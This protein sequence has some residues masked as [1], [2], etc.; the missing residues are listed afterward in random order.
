M[1]AARI[2]A[3][4]RSG[5]LRAADVVRSALDRAEAIA[6][7]GAF[8][9][10]DTAGA[11]AR[12]EAIDAAV[13][14]GEDPGPLAGVP[15]A[16]K[17]N[18]AHEGQPCGCAS[19][20]LEGYIAPYTATAVSRLLGA[21]AVVLGRANMDEFAMG[22]STETSAYGPAYNPWDRGRVPG[23]SSGGSAVAVAAGVCPLALGS[24]TGGS[25]RQPASL[26]GVVGVKPTYGRISRYG[27]VAFGSSVDQIGPIG[28][29]VEDA[30]LATALMSGLDGHDPTTLSAPVPDLV[31]ACAAPVRGLTIG[32][33]EEAWGEGVEPGVIA[34]CRAAL[35]ALV[36]EG[37]RVVP[38]RVPLLPLS[39]AIYQVL[40]ASEASSNLARFD[41]VRYGPREAAETLEQLYVRTRSARFGAEV[42]RRILLGTFA[43]SAGYAD[44]YYGRARAAQ[45]RLA[46]DLALALTGVDAIVTPTS[47]T[48]AFPLGA[49]ASDPLAMYLS[50]IFTAPANL[51]GLPAISVPCGL[52]EGLP[53][54]LQLMGPTL[55]EPTLFALAAAVERAHG[56][57]TPAGYAA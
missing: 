27:L 34:A 54:G 51:A 2:A 25:V 53:V 7:L 22:S 33:A 37:V 5:A 57:L 44:Q 13:R 40:T 30:A 35:D 3:G 14:R 31:S 55:G 11:L 39:I 1:S 48:V 15:V 28:R 18:L 20:V 23:G 36:A 21:G 46:E 8:L 42:Q 26:C 43:L 9:H 32:V 17:D 56:L 12:A 50:D 19:R 29:T 24:E 6:G 16:L 52:S 4:V 47:P 41:G 10:L 49:K 38:V 45:R